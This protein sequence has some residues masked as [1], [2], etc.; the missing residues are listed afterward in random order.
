MFSPALDGVGG[1]SFV[2]QQYL[3]TGLQNR[4]DLSLIPTTRD[5]STGA[6]VLFFIKAIIATIKVL[7]HD[8]EGIYHLHISQNGS[9]FRKFTIFALAKLSNKN[10]VSHIHG[11]NFDEFLSKNF[12]I[13]RLAKLLFTYSDLVIALSSKTKSSLS[14]FECKANISILYNPAPTPE[15]IE[16]INHQGLNVLFLGRLSKRKGSYDLLHVIKENKLYFSQKTVK[17]IIAGDGDIIEHKEF[18]KKNE[19]SDIVLIPG[20]VTGSQKKGYLS[21]ADIYVLPS[22]KE[23]MPMS[24]LEAMAYGL[25][26]I[27]TLV[28]GIPEMVDNGKNG[29]LIEPGDKRGLAFSL[30][31]LIENKGK[32]LSMGKKSIKCLTEKFDCNKIIDELISIYSNLSSRKSFK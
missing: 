13:R 18:V 32:R 20:W 9:F 3:R 30:F 16:V 19:L 27:S 6:K 7:R 2:V 1:I 12:I 31:E 24:I 21:N 23:Q 10:V 8:C 25:P 15:K 11:S 5:G 4:V 14:Q 28:A 17:F 29:I 22:Y 26:I